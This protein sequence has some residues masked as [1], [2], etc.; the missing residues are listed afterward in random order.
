MNNLN[1]V[2]AIGSVVLLVGIL[3][4]MGIG[5]IQERSV[6]RFEPVMSQ[7]APTERQTDQTDTA[8]RPS[9]SADD[10][11]V[12]RLQLDRTKT[13]LIEVMVYNGWGVGEIRAVLKGDNGTIG[14]AVD[15]A[16][17]KLGIDPPERTLRVRDEKG[18]RLIAL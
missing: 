1:M 9:V 7:S 15:A 18:E 14:E 16:R 13:A 3:I 10:L 11:H 17:K 4:S 6:K 2:L 8:D 12:E 5:K